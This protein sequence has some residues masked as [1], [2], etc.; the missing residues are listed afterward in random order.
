M[1]NRLRCPWPYAGGK[2]K[3]AAEIWA[4]FGKVDDPEQEKLL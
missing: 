2:G 3:R 4:R 1:K